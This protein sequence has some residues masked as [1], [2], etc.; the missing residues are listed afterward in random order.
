VSDRY[1]GPERRSNPSAVQTITVAELRAYVET[2]YVSKDMLTDSL[3]DL[4]RNVVSD[5]L[6]QNA[7][8]I[9][10]A[11]HSALQEER[12]WDREEDRRQ[13]VEALRAKIEQSDAEKH[14]EFMEFFAAARKAED[15][16][17]KQE[18]EAERVERAAERKRFM[19]TVYGIAVGATPLLVIVNYV[20]SWMGLW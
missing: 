1:D 18:R 8:V 4:R 16:Q 12:F 5:V 15:E 10:D 19:R 20:G 11:L 14:R 3:E 6:K 7:A 9:K 2:H 13:I 17:R